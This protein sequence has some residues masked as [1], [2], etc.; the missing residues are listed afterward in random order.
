MRMTENP[1]RHQLCFRE[2]K[3]EPCNGLVTSPGCNPACYPA[4]TM[5]SS[6]NPWIELS[7][8]SQ[9][10]VWNLYNLFLFSI[11][12][13]SSEYLFIF[14]FLLNIVS[15]ILC[16][17]TSLFWKVFI[18]PDFWKNFN[19]LKSWNIDLSS[20]NLLCF[21][22]TVH[23]RTGIWNVPSRIEPNPTALMFSQNGFGAVPMVSFHVRTSTSSISICLW[24]A[25]TFIRPP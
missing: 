5:K 15:V 3:Y 19:T 17:S 13:I 23:H 9:I 7:H 2:G 20:Q 16:V 10:L 22:Y 11:G 4:T 24:V 8:G 21:K 6:S 1:H 18:L 12:V 25:S 14:H